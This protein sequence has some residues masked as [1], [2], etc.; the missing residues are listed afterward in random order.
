MNKGEDRIVDI[1]VILLIIIVIHFKCIGII[2]IPWIWLL[3]PIWILFGI[4]LIAAVI[5]F[6]VLLITICKDKRRKK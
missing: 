2:T 3:S 5:I 4:V 6:I 1:T